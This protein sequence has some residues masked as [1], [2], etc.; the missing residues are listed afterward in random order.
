MSHHQ[1]PEYVGNDNDDVW[2][3]FKYDYVSWISKEKANEKINNHEKE[4]WEEYNHTWNY[5]ECENEFQDIFESSGKIK[6]IFQEKNIPKGVK[7]NYYKIHY[8][9][10]E[11]KDNN[12]KCKKNILNN[13]KC[14]IKKFNYN[15]NCIFFT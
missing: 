13:K 14:I 4:K 10:I 3:F 15:M 5:I 1:N 2:G 12:H 11:K 9:S 8:N 7:I 6:L